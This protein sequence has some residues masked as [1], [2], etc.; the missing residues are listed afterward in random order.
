[1]P[2]KPNPLDAID[3]FESRAFRVGQLARRLRTE[4]PRLGIEDLQ[5]Q[6]FS[7]ATYSRAL[8]LDI[9]A[10]DVTQARAW[11]DV[12]DIELAHKVTAYEYGG[13]YESVTGEATVDGV[14]VTLHGGRMLSADEMATV[15]AGEMA[16]V[17][18]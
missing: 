13:G 11:A 18:S 8:S 2:K 12:L 15:L 17:H 5:A 10:T 7:S 14:L 6:V 16:A 9:T 4:H 1:M 3:L